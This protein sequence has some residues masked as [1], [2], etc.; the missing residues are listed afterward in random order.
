[1]S[2]S[3]NGKNSDGTNG[4]ITVK[5]FAQ[6][7]NVLDLESLAPGLRD[8]N[9]ETNAMLDNA[10]GDPK[11]TLIG[12]QPSHSRPQLDLASV[13][14]QIANVSSGLESMAREQ[15]TIEL[16]AVRTL[17]AERTEAEHALAD[18][19]RGSPPRRAPSA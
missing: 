16:R 6:L 2:S 3:N 5:S 14:A 12:E 15:A 10:A 11:L 13:I 4:S 1:M 8:A 9:E 7:A 19:A 18:A 17:A